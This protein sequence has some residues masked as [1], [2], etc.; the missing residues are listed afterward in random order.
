MRYPPNPTAIV[1]PKDME[2]GS[3]T[4]RLDA[5][6]DSKHLLRWWHQHQAQW[7]VSE[8]DGVR[9][10]LLQ[11]LFGIRRQLELMTG[12]DHH[13]LAAVE[14][15]Y[16]ALEN[17]GDRLSSPFVQE[18]LPLA[19]QHALK[20]W[21]DA[22][23]LEVRLPGHWP[24]EPIEHVT[25]VLSILEH[26]RQTLIALPSPPQTCTVE[27]TAESGIKQLTFHL[28]FPGLPLA[29]EGCRSTDWAYHLL[30]FEAITGGQARCTHS[31]C[32]ILWQLIW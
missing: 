9:N 8:A 22:L 1:W 10:G 28:H 26:L 21:S 5:A 25:L 27:L 17:L 3:L 23:A 32:T 16:G 20:R 2:N 29:T 15:L 31:G 7:L 12:G 6:T 4:E 30:T 14:H 13:A 18:S 11:E 24:N 19:M